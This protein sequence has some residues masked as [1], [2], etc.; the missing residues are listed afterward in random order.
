LIGHLSALERRDERAITNDDVVKSMDAGELRT[1]EEPARQLHIVGGRLWI[2]AGV[3]VGE[4]DRG[5]TGGE[6]G[7]EDLAG[8]HGARARRAFSHADILKQR[9]A[10]V[11]AK[12]VELLPSEPMECGREISVDLGWGPEPRPAFLAALDPTAKFTSGEDSDG[13]LRGHSRHSA[14]MERVLFQEGFE[15]PGAGQQSIG[16]SYSG[17]T[18]QK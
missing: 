12:N 1:F 16:L 2:A 11:E 14:E 17:T 10:R 4:Y 13:A 9:V 18:A 15:S 6:R 7:G 3:V 5:N 8:I